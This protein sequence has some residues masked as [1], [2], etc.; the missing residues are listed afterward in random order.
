MERKY[1][2]P[3]NSYLTPEQIRHE[4]ESLSKIADKYGMSE[5]GILGTLIVG[6]NV[7]AATFSAL[8]RRGLMTKVLVPPLTAGLTTYWPI[9]NVGMVSVFLQM[10][11]I[12]L[13]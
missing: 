9:V 3:M 1:Y 7:G 6:V 4:D 12:K 8:K 13:I 10:I 5:T 11:I 2:W